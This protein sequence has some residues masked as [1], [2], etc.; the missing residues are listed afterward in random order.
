MRDIVTMDEYYTV[1]NENSLVVVKFYTPSCP[2]CNML[3]PKLE[4]LEKNN[5]QITFVQV[6]CADRN[7]NISEHF[8]IYSVPVVMCVKNGKIKNTV[9]GGNFN[10]IK[11]TIQDM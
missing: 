6:N 4:E 9:L 8:D 1:I 7:T 2:P 10:E 3:K 11:K 5:S